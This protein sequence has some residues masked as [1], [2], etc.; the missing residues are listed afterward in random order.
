[1]SVPCKIHTN[2]LTH[3]NASK[4]QP[5]KTTV[6]NPAT[7]IAQP[8]THP[9]THPPTSE[10]IHLLCPLHVP[11]G[12]PVAGS[13]SQML[14]SISPLATSAPSGDQDT[15]STQFLWPCVWMVVGGRGAGKG[16]GRRR[17]RRRRGGRD[18]RCCRLRGTRC[19]ATHG[20][21]RTCLMYHTHKHAHQTTC[22]SFTLPVVAAMSATNLTCFTTPT[23]SSFP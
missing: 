3:N 4:Q 19:G 10:V 15:H 23:Q 5:P 18:G 22:P 16:S 20:H 8:S 11:S 7:P 12:L 6:K 1:M 2:K 9:P 21:A 14:P 17:S 13:H